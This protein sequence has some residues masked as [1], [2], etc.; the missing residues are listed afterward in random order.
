[1]EWNDDLSTQSIEIAGECYSQADVKLLQQLASD[2]E[3]PQFMRAVWQFLSEWFDDSPTITVHT[4]GSTGTPKFMYVEKQL[5]MESAKLTCSTLHLNRSHTALLCMNLRYI[6]AKMMVVRCLVSGMKL[7]VREAG[8]H[9][10]C[11]VDEHI[12][13]MAIVP[14]QLFHTLQNRDECE[15]LDHVSCIIVGGGS[16]DAQLLEPLQHMHCAVYSTYGMTETLSHIA[17]CRL[18]GPGAS[19]YYTPLQ[20]VSC[21]TTPQGCL[22]IDAQHLRVQALRTNDVVEMNA[23]GGFKVLGRCDNIVNSGG[24]KIQIE[25]DEACLRNYLHTGFALTSVPDVRLGQ[26]LVLLILDGEQ[27]SDASLLELMRTHLPLYHVAKHIV[28]VSGIPLTEN[29][30]INRTACCELALSNIKIQ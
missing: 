20:G 28:R 29:G 8:S 9:P 19:C 16:V 12:D 23:D 18:N 15:R 4:S 13:F 22:V 6:G 7:V 3:Q 2:D 11:D 26:A 5:M 24:I 10:L 27:L 17:L 30:K 25:V 1:M 21:S 14:L